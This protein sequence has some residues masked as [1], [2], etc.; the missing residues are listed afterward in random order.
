VFPFLFAA[1]VIVEGL[2]Q[3]EY[4]HVSM[5]ISALAA[6]PY[7]RIQVANF[8]VAGT[9]LTLFAVVQHRGVRPTKR[10]VLG[11]AFQF[12]GACD[13]VLVGTP[14]PMRHLVSMVPSGGIP[15]AA[16]NGRKRR[17]RMEDAKSLRLRQMI[18]KSLIPL[19]FEKARA[20]TPT[21]SAIRL[22]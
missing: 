13:G 17:R 21:L 15:Q 6:F 1:L 9:L 22:R 12:I 18:T 20:R 2:L 10:G 14:S 8:L 11:P 16:A 19:G 4:S 7:G 5:P 3:P